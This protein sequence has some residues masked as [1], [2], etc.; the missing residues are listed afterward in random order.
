[1]PRGLLYILLSLFF[2]FH[3][4]AHSQ[5]VY[6]DDI[7]E[8][9]AEGVGIYIE[10]LSTGD[11]VLDVNGEIPMIPASTTKLITTATVLET[12]D[13]DERFSTVFSIVGSIKDSTLIG[14]LII[15]PSGDPTLNSSY[16]KG[17]T[18]PFDSI[19]HILSDLGINR[20]EGEILIDTP[21][22]LE[23]SIPKGWKDTDLM[24]PYGT[25]HHALN[26]RDNKMAFSYPG[27]VTTPHTP[28][29]IVRRHPKGKGGVRVERKAGS[30]VFDVY[31]SPKKKINLT[32][33]NP[34]PD[35]AFVYALRNSLAMNGISIEGKKLNHKGKQREIYRHQSPTF[36]EILKNMMLRSD[37]LYAEGMLR[38]LAP[39]GTRSDA[40][41]FERKFWYDNGIDTCGLALNDGSG[42]S[43]DNRIAPYVFADVLVWMIDNGRY[44]SQYLSMFPRAGQ[45][46]TL[47]NFLKGTE[48]EGRLVAK[49]GSVNGVQCY[50]GYMLNPYGMPTHVVVIMIN[51]FDVNRTRL[52][53]QL[54]QLL[55]K[56]L[57]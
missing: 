7:P 40:L 16:L 38:V 49:T 31:A 56:K 55:L 39:N 45:N 9:K 30:S 22:D 23:F 19:A 20:I 2:A 10:D 48:L 52:K 51:D 53:Y 35:S 25:G 54:Q 18:V 21:K 33:A 47:R 3:L 28:G 43:R 17:T 27:S 42:L 14:N 8:L 36:G 26:Y 46:G 5:D 24:H 34:L 29:I 1:M 15:Q 4:N 32:V 6:T 13:I 57:L 41:N 37:N 50:A 11:V 12:H 44:A